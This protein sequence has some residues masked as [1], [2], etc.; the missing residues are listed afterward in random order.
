MQ[1]STKSALEK[2]SDSNQLFL[3]LFT[4][5]SLSIEVYKPIEKD[6]QKPHE[7]DELYI[8]ISGEGNFILMEKT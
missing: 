2:L 7:K 1:I 3:E 5:G 4:H 8:I 6:F